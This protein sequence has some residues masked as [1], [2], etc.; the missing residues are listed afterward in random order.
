MIFKYYKQKYLEKVNFK[1]DLA[2]STK[3]ERSF[4]KKRLSQFLTP[5]RSL[6][7]KSFIL[8]GSSANSPLIIRK[9]VDLHQRTLF[10]HKTK[11]SKF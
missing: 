3:Q 4:C 11:N 10:E 1:L 9:V 8:R 5:L 2:Q 6:C 7:P